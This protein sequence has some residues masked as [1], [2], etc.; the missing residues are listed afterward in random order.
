MFTLSVTITVSMVVVMRI[1]LFL[2][3]G[4]IGLG[5]FFS[6]SFLGLSGRELCMPRRCFLRLYSNGP[7]PRAG[8]GGHHT[9]C[10]YYDYYLL[11]SH[12]V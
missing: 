12:S 4:G 8:T 3:A 6:R 7:C 1:V 2:L 10:E 9:D 11:Y 5:R